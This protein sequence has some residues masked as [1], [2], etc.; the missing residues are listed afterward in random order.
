L[1][2]AVREAIKG[3]R[4]EVVVRK[5]QSSRYLIF[6]EHRMNFG[7]SNPR[8]RPLR[9]MSPLFFVSQLEVLIANQAPASR[10]EPVLAELRKNLELMEM[11]LDQLRSIASKPKPEDR[12]GE[13]T[14]SIPVVLSPE[15]NVP[16][17]PPQA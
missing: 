3:S 14:A 13:N 5:M 4:R 12:P 10:I 11:E 6:M 17:D 1:I 9:A 7:F 16:I 8:V 2:P 15:L